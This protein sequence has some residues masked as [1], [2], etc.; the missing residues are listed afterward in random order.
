MTQDRIE[1]KF[2]TIGVS[3]VMKSFTLSIKVGE[4]DTM[5]LFKA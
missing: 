4:I 3:F 5:P 1:K 2:I